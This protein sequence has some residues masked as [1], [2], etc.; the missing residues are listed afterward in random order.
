LETDS[1]GHAVRVLTNDFFAAADPSIS[2]DGSKILFAARK[3]QASM[4]QI[5]EIGVDGSKPRQI[6]QNPADCL[7]PNYLAHETIAFT[8]VTKTAIPVSQTTAHDARTAAHEA[9]QVWTSKLDGSGAAPITFGPGNFQVETVLQN[10]TL[11]LTADS[12]L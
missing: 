6:T 1:T 7:Q 9:S 12:P 5:W 3:S 2:P 8:V 10:G 4:W 11:L